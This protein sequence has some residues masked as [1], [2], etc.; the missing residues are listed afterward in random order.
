MEIDEQCQATYTAYSA[1]TRVLIAAA[2]K[3]EH[4]NRLL[5]RGEYAKAIEITNTVLEARGSEDYGYYWAYEIQGQA[6]Y[7]LGRVSKAITAFENAAAEAPR[8]KQRG[9]LSGYVTELKSKGSYVHKSERF[10]EP[11]VRMPPMFPWNANE[12]GHCEMV[13]DVDSK[14]VTNNIQ[15]AYCSNSIFAKSSIEAVEKWK[16]APKINNGQ[17]VNI[18]G[19][20]TRITFKLSDECGNTIPAPKQN[21]D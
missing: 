15:A 18:E 12:S 3:T 8:E 19:I 10:P 4:A 21:N 7:K 20:E 13:F 6:L 2:R 16:Y 5:R 17:A 14:G 9:E 11:L 1:E